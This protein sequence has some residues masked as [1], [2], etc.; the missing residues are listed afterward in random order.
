MNDSA[1]ASERASGDSLRRASEEVLTRTSPSLNP[2]MVQLELL[3]LK[4]DAE[5]MLVSQFC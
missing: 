2:E 4:E 1:R 3:D 5:G